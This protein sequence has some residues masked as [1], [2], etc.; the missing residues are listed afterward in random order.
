M[1]ATPDGLC[2]TCNDR[3]GVVRRLDVVA[4]GGERREYELVLCRVCTDAFDDDELTTI[5]P[6]TD[7]RSP[8]R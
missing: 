7:S 4:R 2:T 3:D 1:N 8:D 5:E 6:S